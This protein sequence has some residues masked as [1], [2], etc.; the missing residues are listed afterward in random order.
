MYHALMA[1]HQVA[2]DKRLGVRPIE[3]GETLHCAFAKL[4]SRAARDQAKTACVSLQMCAGLEAGIE[5]GN[6]HCGVKVKGEDYTR[7]RGKG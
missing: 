2:L 5:T 6:P 7:D 3:I 4:V 1:C